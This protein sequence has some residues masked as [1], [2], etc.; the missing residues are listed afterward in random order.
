AASRRG[1][2]AHATGAASKR[3][4]QDVWLNTEKTVNGGDA[5][6]DRSGQGGVA[7]RHERAAGGGRPP[8]GLPAHGGFRR[9]VPSVRVPFTGFHSQAP[10]EGMLNIEAPSRE[11]PGTPRWRSAVDEDV[12]PL[13]VALDERPERS[14]VGAWITAGDLRL[15]ELREG[16]LLAGVL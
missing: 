9:P 2:I 4:R 13:G 8:G 1:A 6:R 12:R 10:R 3:A 14:E 16:L 15:A 11:R 5:A 7:P